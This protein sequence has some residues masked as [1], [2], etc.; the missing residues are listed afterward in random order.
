MNFLSIKPLK[1]FMALLSGVLLVFAFAPFY[2]FYLAIVAL[3]ILLWI[4]LDTSPKRAGWRGFLFGLGLFGVG[5][6]WVY[7]SIHTY[8]GTPFLIA[9]LITILFVIILSSIL[10]LN[11]YLWRRF[12]SYNEANTLL[13][14]F[15]ILW[16]LFEWF[17]SVIFTGFPWLFLGYSQTHSILS[18]LAPIGSVYLI[19]FLVALNASL[20]VFALTRPRYWLHSFIGIAIIWSLAFSFYNVHWTERQS[21]ALKVALVQGNVPQSLKWN[22]DQ[23]HKTLALYK[24]VTEK[25]WDQ[26]IIVWPE[27]AVPLLKDQAEE[28]LNNL[29]QEAGKNHVALILGLPVSEQDHYYNAILGLGSAM[30]IYYKR[31]LVPFGEYVPLQSW[32]R[33]LI[34]FFDLPMSDFSPGPLQQK[35]LNLLGFDLATYLCYEVAYLREFLTQFPNAQ[36]IVTL[37]N[38]A[39][40]GDS[41]AASQQ[42]QMAQMRSLETG[43]YQLVATDNGITA[44]IDSKGRITAQLP[45][46][47]MGVLKG[48]VYAM[49]GSTPL[50]DLGSGPLL[51]ILWVLLALS[52][53]FRREML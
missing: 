11:T 29:N 53:A 39:W 3:A 33:G 32:L 27:A 38:D 14:A 30:G 47:E 16:V 40:F 21:T 35:P 37:S 28:Y 18:S 12:F 2:Q 4:L 26:N 36:L 46:F 24:T 7:I 43:R 5:A 8:G 22:P 20:I 45:Q 49:Y 48:Q 41:F 50:M 6:S 51:F 42:L 25:L 1:D 15:P 44:I 9:A 17:R 23:A 31:H 13:L 52:F 10:A 34:G 19:S